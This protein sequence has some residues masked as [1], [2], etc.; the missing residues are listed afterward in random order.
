[1]Q[2]QKQRPMRERERERAALRHGDGPTRRAE[3]AFLRQARGGARPASRALEHLV[4]PAHGD[5]SDV[6]DDAGAVWATVLAIELPPAG[7]S[8]VSTS[9]LSC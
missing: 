1:M 3:S 6:G 4:Q 9:K 2:G 5:W 8:L 7:S